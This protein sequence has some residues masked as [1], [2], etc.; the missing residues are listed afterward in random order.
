M[1]ELSVKSDIHS[2]IVANSHMLWYRK[3][4]S[5]QITLEFSVHGGIGGDLTHWSVGYVVVAKKYNVD[6]H[7][8][9]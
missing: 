7:F 3:L 8:S 6:T 4:Y 1:N 5:L 9:E 2:N